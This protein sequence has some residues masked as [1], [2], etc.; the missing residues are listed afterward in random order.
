VT[1]DSAMDGMYEVKWASQIFSKSRRLSYEV[2][3]TRQAQQSL[4]QPSGA[5]VYSANLSSSR[6][7][8][9]H[10][11]IRNSSAHVLKSEMKRH[12]SAFAQLSASSAVLSLNAFHAVWS[13]IVSMINF[14][15]VHNSLFRRYCEMMTEKDSCCYATAGKGRLKRGIFVKIHVC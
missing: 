12:F 11:S 14:V 8:S 5:I 7:S 1:G 4:S 2:V 15:F 10:L 6:Y 13:L 9:G 3:L